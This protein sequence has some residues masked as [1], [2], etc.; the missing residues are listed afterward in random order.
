MREY[1]DIGIQRQKEYAKTV[2]H[3]IPSSSRSELRPHR[4]IAT[5]SVDNYKFA[6]T[7]FYH[8]SNDGEQLRRALW[9]VLCSGWWFNNIPTSGSELVWFVERR[10][11]KEF[12]CKFC[13]VV[14]RKDR[15]ALACVCAHIAYNP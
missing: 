5:M 6:S 4:N 14:Y 7:C 1:N 8:R 13:S 15:E 3:T 11:S 9:N 10:S 2:P 12:E